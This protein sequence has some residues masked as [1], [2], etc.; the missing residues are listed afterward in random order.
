MLHA[1]NE[2]L[3]S[4]GTRLQ[5]SHS[6]H[7]WHVWLHNT[8][9]CLER[10]NSLEQLARDFQYKEKYC[11]LLGKILT[12]ESPVTILVHGNMRA[13]ETAWMRRDHERWH[14]RED[15]KR[16]NQPGDHKRRNQPG[17]HERRHQWA[18]K[19]ASTSTRDGINKENQ[20]R[21]ESTRDS[22]NNMPQISNATIFSSC[23]MLVNHK[24][25]HC[26]TCTSTR[27]LIT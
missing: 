1:R 11:I 3:L 25:I 7:A 2:G 4:R 15:H 14:K 16:R 26:S 9:E 12:K 10:V 13:W 5:I 23:F 21:Q 19:T 24:L 8:C 20:D 17:D 6:R 18:R 22:I 27:V